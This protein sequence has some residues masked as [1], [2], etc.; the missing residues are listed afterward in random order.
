MNKNTIEIIQLEQMEKK[1][2]DDRHS[3][4][5]QYY[6]YEVITLY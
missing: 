6:I 1:E 5:C 4:I 2:C 3:M